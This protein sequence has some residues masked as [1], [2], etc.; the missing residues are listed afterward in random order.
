MDSFHTNK[1]KITAYVAAVLCMASVGVFAAT[2]H[3]NDA[4]LTPQA[5]TRTA[6]SDNTDWQEW[7][8]HWE[9]IKSDYE[10][11]SIAPG[12]NESKLNFAWYSKEKAD[13]AE[14]RISRN[15]DMSK[16]KT[17]GGVCQ[18]GTV[19][20]GKTYYANKVEISGLKADS[21][22]WYQ[23]KK[24]GQWQKA[25]MI[26]TGNPHDFSFMYVGDPQIGASKGQTPAD[27]AKKMNGDMAARNDA[28]NWNKTLNAALAQHQDIDFLVSPGDQINEPAANQDPAKILQ[29]EE[30]YAGY[31]SARALRSLPEASSIGNHDSMTVGYG[32]HFNV[33]NPFVEEKNPTVAGHGY[34]YAYGSALFI[35]INANNYNAADHQALIQKAI[36]AYPDAK[37]R[38]V[39]MHQDIYG[40]GLD[41]SDSDGILLRTQLTPIYD[42]N[43]IDVVLQGHD[44]TYARTYQISSDGKKHLSFSDL[45]G[46]GQSG[47]SHSLLDTALKNSAFKDMYTSQNLCY[48]IADMKQGVLHNPQG[49]FY[50]SSNSATGSKFYELIPQQQDYIAAR[51][52]TW[53]PTYSVIRVT[54]TSFTI[55]T[56]DVESGAPI[57]DAYSIVKD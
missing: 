38:I 35:V 13:R 44:H 29:Q 42:A 41:H 20:G 25:E 26:K 30:E 39:V 40:S 3:W 17:F 28:Y 51:S 52:Q 45:R 24:N 6:V 16:A 2:S 5:T 12:T 15:E 7:K 32:N 46:Q 8:A 11:V 36:A 48:T 1:K 19:I 22:Y 47:Q 53:R 43:H 33:P 49:V 56:Y 54:D 34:Y 14:V 55:N 23:V 31:L 57:D 37:W 10:Q 50:M 27:G 21:T 4:S 18:E 9:E